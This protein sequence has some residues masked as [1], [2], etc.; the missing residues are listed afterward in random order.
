MQAGLFKFEQNSTSFLLTAHVS[1]PV[2]LLTGLHIADNSKL[3]ATKAYHQHHHP[4]KNNN[5]YYLFTCKSHVSETKIIKIKV[6][7]V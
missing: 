6:H 4:E 7:T 3:K 1:Q 5:C 2:Q